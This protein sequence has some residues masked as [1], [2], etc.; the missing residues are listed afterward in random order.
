MSD[1]RNLPPTKGLGLTIAPDDRD[2]D[3][4]VQLRAPV[5][6]RKT[7]RWAYFDHPLDQGATGTCVGFAA[8][9]VLMAGP[10]IQAEGRGDEPN[11]SAIDLYREFVKHDP[12]PA[13]DWGD[14]QFGT[15]MNAMG[16]GLRKLGYCD[17]WE[18]GYSVEKAADYLA[19]VDDAGN[20][21]GGPIAFGIPW[22]SGM[23]E[24]DSEG[25]L[26][27]TGY[28]VGGHAIA[29]FMWNETK[30]E[31]WGPNSWGNGFGKYHPIRG[32]DGYWRMTG[33]NMQKL[34]NNGGEFISF[35]EKRV[36]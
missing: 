15:S 11:P 22:Y 27:P 36:L 10:V 20:H 2:H 12:W 6:K 25:Y 30:G 14:L 13:N 16:R 33:E 7:R 23:F 18:H 21:V 32:K 28:Q 35:R 9:H 26:H 29:C 8:K 17:M 24:T 5:T 19:G 4:P 34:L 1:D 3:F 31:F